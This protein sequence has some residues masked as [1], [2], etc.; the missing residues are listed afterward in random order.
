[1]AM[2]KLRGFVWTLTCGV[3]V[4]YCLL[5]LAW[6]I[7]HVRDI[8]HT[9]WGACTFASRSAEHEGV[10]VRRV[11]IPT[12]I[13]TL[14]SDTVHIR[15]AWVERRSRIV[16]RFVLLR[17]RDTMDGYNLCVATDRSEFGKFGNGGYAELMEGD[18]TFGGWRGTR[19]SSVTIRRTGEPFPDSLRFS[20]CEDKRFSDGE[21]A[22]R[23]H[24]W[25]PGC[26][27]P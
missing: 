21:P 9:S 27:T 4:A 19:D 16:Y 3:L 24:A 13:L 2:V 23:T 18:S 8:E 26:P 22:R 11:P 7:D 25:L 5:R 1:M 15:E 10:L 6:W 20:F 17:T 12:A 14:G